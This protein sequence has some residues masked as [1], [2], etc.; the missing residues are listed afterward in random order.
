MISLRAESLPYVVIEAAAARL[1]MVATNVGGI[2]EIVG[3]F[4]SELIPPNDPAALAGAMRR[5]KSMPQ[6]EANQRTAALSAFVHEHFTISAMTTSILAAC[7]QA[8]EK[9]RGAAKTA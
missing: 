6:E 1:P 3:P 8:V 7:A 9:K 2:P 4:A 5:L